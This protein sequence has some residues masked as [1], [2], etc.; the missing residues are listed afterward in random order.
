MIFRNSVCAVFLL[1]TFAGAAHA[2]EQANSAD[3]DNSKSSSHKSVVVGPRLVQSTEP[4]YTDRARKAKIQGEVLVALTVDTD[5]VPRDL[6][7]V[8]SLE[9]SLDEVAMKSV[10]KYRFAPA[11]RDGQPIAVTVNVSVNF[12]IR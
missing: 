10:A 6:H 4:H 2:Q 3:Q 1:L 5:G 7:V 11:T 12:H 8:R 9:P